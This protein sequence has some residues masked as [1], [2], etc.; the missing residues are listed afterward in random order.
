M[1]IVSHTQSYTVTQP[2]LLLPFLLEKLAP[3]S[4]TKIKTML[5]QGSVLV[6]GAV[7]TKHDFVLLVG[8]VVKIGERTKPK[9]GPLHILYEDEWILVVEKPSG[10]LS[11]GNPTTKEENAWHL[12]RAYVRDA[13]VQSDV[14]VCHRL[15]QYTSGILLFAKDKEVQMTLR[16]SWNDYVL[17]R[18]YVAVTEVVPNPPKAELRSYLMENAAMQVYSTRNPHVG[19]LAITRYKVVAVNGKMALLDIQILTGRKNQIRVQLSEHGWCIAGDR[20]YGAKTDPE[21]RLMLHNNRLAFVHPV[22]HKELVFELPLP[23]SFAKHFKIK[24]S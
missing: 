8:S 23:N 13:D 7:Q 5:G 3:Q 14:Y 17:D 10:L 4:R 22:T 11:V 6:D 9:N 20:K 24:L 12:L 19:K 15:D 2:T 18:R 16:D 21:H 1:G